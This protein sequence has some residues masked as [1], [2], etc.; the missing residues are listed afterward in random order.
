M[1]LNNR[2]LKGF[3]RS[4]T[5]FALALMLIVPKTT[6]LA[7]AAEFVPIHKSSSEKIFIPFR[8]EIPHYLSLNSSK[9]S[10]IVKMLWKKLYTEETN[11]NSSTEGFSSWISKYDDYYLSIDGTSKLLSKGT[12]NDKIAGSSGDFEAF[13]GNTIKNNPEFLGEIL[14]INNDNSSGVMTDVVCTYLSDTTKYK[15]FPIK[16]ANLTAEGLYIGASRNSEDNILKNGS[17]NGT[18]YDLYVLNALASLYEGDGDE[19]YLTDKQVTWIKSYQEFLYNQYVTMGDKSMAKAYPPVY[20]LIARSPYAAN[21]VGGKG[22]EFFNYVVA[23]KTGIGTWLNMN[24]NINIDGLDS[25]NDL[26]PIFEMADGWCCGYESE[27]VCGDHQKCISKGTA[28]DKMAYLLYKNKDAMEYISNCPSINDLIQD[29]NGEYGYQTR[30]EAKH[31]GAGLSGRFYKEFTCGNGYSGST[32]TTRNYGSDG[33]GDVTAI[34]TGTVAFPIGN[35]SL[36]NSSTYVYVNGVSSPSAGGWYNNKLINW[37]VI[38]NNN[39]IATMSN[40]TKVQAKF[41]DKGLQFCIAGLSKNERTNAIIY[42]TAQSYKSYPLNYPKGSPWPSFTSTATVSFKNSVFLEGYYPD[43]ITNGH[44]YIV[45]EINDSVSW[46]D[47]YSTAT[48]S[49]I[50]SK[51][52]SH[53]PKPITVKSKVST[54]GDYIVYTAYSP[55]INKSVTKRVSKTNGSTTEKIILDSTNSFGTLFVQKSSNERHYPAGSLSNATYKIASSNISVCTLPG[56]IK[57]GTKSIKV[58]ISYGRQLSD[59]VIQIRSKTGEEL[60]RNDQTFC[61]I[62]DGNGDSQYTNSFSVQLPVTVS[63]IDLIDCVVVITAHSITQNWTP[64]RQPNANIP[65]ANTYIKINSITAQY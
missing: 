25:Y 62:P 52:V 49:P 6:S 27:N 39:S 31:A 2:F 24:D 60:G 9:K 14:G 13:F 30:F 40:Q 19:Q 26:A 22:Q 34:H 21:N 28:V 8:N 48:F 4:V 11:W 54:E 50:C 23:S 37:S 33:N 46:S 56:V 53:T 3:R 47:D 61:S 41:T 29:T 59:L 63:D 10:E 20:N 32:S 58:D 45:S 7:F 36:I 35:L 51:E 55:E 38:V 42:I 43:C 44:N 64:T 65:E 17:H 15:I 57:S 5:A 18:Q 16:I 1:F 12:K